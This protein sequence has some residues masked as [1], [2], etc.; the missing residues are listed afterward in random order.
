MRKESHS[1]GLLA[2][3]ETHNALLLSLSYKHIKSEYG[4]CGN[5]KCKQLHRL[6]TILKK[7]KIKTLR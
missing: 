1:A 2:L 5:Y 4:N 7:I 6:P 3:N